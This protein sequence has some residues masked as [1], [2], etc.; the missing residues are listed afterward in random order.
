ML[1][2]EDVLTV[3]EACNILKVSKKTL[4][5]LVRAGGL[6]AVKVGRGWR[7]LRPSLEDYLRGDNNNHDN[8]H[9]RDSN[10]YLKND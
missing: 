2:K 1:T 7:I 8:M 4:Y 3:N 6:H 9:S 5:N 10:D